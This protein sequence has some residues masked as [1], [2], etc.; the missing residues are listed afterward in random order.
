MSTAWT[1]EVLITVNRY[2]TVR[3]V[4]AQ[5]PYREAELI[6]SGKG[7]EV[8][9]TVVHGFQW[10]TRSF[11]EQQT[12]DRYALKNQSEINITPL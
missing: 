6:L 4:S 5:V 1:L 3:N 10:N 11:R 2:R 8:K 9:H 7:S 12:P